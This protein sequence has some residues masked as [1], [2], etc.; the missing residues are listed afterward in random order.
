[1]SPSWA[2]R[3]FDCSLH[4]VVQYFSEVGSYGTQFAHGTFSVTMTV[5]D[6]HAELEVDFPAVPSLLYQLSHG[7]FQNASYCHPF[8]HAAFIFSGDI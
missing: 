2:F 6:V 3:A 8:E 5:F 4:A 7:Q 1:V